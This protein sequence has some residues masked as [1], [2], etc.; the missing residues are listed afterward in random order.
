MWSGIRLQ[1]TCHIHTWHFASMFADVSM[2]AYIAGRLMYKV[3]ENDHF[4]AIYLSV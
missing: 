2:I 1:V 4:K 3:L